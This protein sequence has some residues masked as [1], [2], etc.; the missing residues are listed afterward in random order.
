MGRPRVDSEE[1]SARIQRALLQRLEQW[2]AKHDIPR[3]EAIRRL[4]QIALDADKE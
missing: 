1:V 2:A 4:I 3:A